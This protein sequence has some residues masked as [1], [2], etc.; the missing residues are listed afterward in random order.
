MSVILF[1][2]D[3]AVEQPA[4]GPRRL[5]WCDGKVQ[6]Y[7]LHPDWGLCAVLLDVKHKR[8][9]MRALKECKFVREESDLAPSGP[10][11]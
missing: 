11:I 9:T 6:Q 4:S 1:Y 7:I 5:E 8:I 3:T 10:L 2:Q